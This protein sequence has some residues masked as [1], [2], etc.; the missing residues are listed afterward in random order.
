MSAYLHF[1]FGPVQSF[2]AQ[3]RRTRD[4]YA[5]SFLLSHLAMK[6]MEAVTAVDGT[7][8][9]PDWQ[10]L[11]NHSSRDPSP[12]AVAPNRFLAAF[13]D[14]TA[15]AQAGRAAAEA[16][17]REWQRFVGAVWERFVQP[18]APR[19]RDTGA[20][21]DR[22]GKAFWEI[23]WA[24]ASDPTTDPL[25][26][27][28]HW[29]IPPDTVEPGDHC[30]LMGQWQELS[31]YVR[32]VER[33][34][35]NDFWRAMREHA[36]KMGASALDLQEDERLC[37]IA[38]VKR[39]FPLLS[40]ALLG[41]PL[42]IET[43]PST[44]TIAAVPWLR[45][46]KSGSP[47]LL[48]QCAAYARRLGQQPGALTSG[49]SRLAVLRTFPPEAG[50][51]P[52]LSGNF[53]NRNTLSNE[54]TTP[55]LSDTNRAE[56]LQ[57]L[58]QLEAASGDRV[59]NFYAV[60]L[61][62]GDGMGRL[63]R[64]H[65]ADK[66]TACL[67]AFAAHVP[68]IIEGEEH[69]G[70]CVYAG[71]D[72][73]LAMLP[74]DSAL[75]ATVAVRQAYLEAF[76]RVDLPRASIS[77]GL[78]FAHYRCTFSRTLQYAHALLHTL[79]KEQAGRDALA[80]GV[81]KPGGIVCEWVEKFDHAIQGQSHCFAPLIEAFRKGPADERGGLSSSFLYNLRLRLAPL[82]ENPAPDTGHGVW[83]YSPTLQK[84][85]MA[86]YLHGRL[87]RDPEEAK[88]QQQEAEKL[89]R[90]LLRICSRAD[91]EHPEHRRPD[92]NGLRLLK[93]LALNG[94]EGSE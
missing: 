37:A 34:Q 45:T 42:G 13:N 90:D 72:D 87:S 5:G 66:V 31:G 88:A 10:A 60:L 63:L 70:V 77:A 35:Q 86:E 59:G 79:A 44:V 41:R 2:I 94:K 84:L 53:L 50:D 24:V 91:V 71:G 29:R 33:S 85:V 36:R 57:Q 39:F 43:W 9:V 65:P 22:Q 52:R 16:I 55:L 58:Q 15:A 83:P 1:S 3:A 32:P 46:V 49:S 21:W 26:S 93:F 20:I 64:E 89:A 19:G 47:E 12:H 51:F 67:S 8:L 27:R 76:R 4:L 14:E 80:I 40:E 17:R 25:G 78:A 18:V 74:V 82:F 11:R 54:R 30:T 23:Y 62:D 48:R 69:S 6:A 61:M 7:I 75:P 38:L 68:K 28:K 56:L 73:L 81:L 92:F